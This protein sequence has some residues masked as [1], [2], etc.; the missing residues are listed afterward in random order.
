MATALMVLSWAAV[1]LAVVPEFM[2]V[3]MNSP[4]SKLEK[5]AYAQATAQF[6]SCDN[7]FEGTW[8]ERY[9][10]LTECVSENKNPEGWVAWQPFETWDWN[11][12]VEQI[13]SEA[14]SF[15]ITLKQVL[16]YAKNGIVAS[17]IDCS[18]DSDMNL[19]DMI[20]LVEIG[21]EEQ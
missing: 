18:L 13:D 19:L 15:L 4:V 1:R 8:Y 17:A 12:I 2:E 6:V 20:Q 14:N 5:M 10:Y 16:E 11:D 3:M 21:S 9:Q 7:N